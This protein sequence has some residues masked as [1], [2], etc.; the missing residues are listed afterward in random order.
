MQVSKLRFFITCICY[1]DYNIWFENYQMEHFSDILK[2]I[3]GVIR[4]RK[5]KEL[6]PYLIEYILNSLD[7]LKSILEEK[8]KENVASESKLNTKMEE[9]IKRGGLL[10]AEAKKAAKE[11]LELEDEWFKLDDEYKK[12]QKEAEKLKEEEDKLNKEKEDSSNKS[13]LLN[14]S[15][16]IA[17]YLIPI[18]LV[19]VATVA[20]INWAVESSKLGN[21]KNKKDQQAKQM[22]EMQGL[23]DEQKKKVETIQLE[24]MRIMSERDKLDKS[25]KFCGSVLT[26][27]RNILKDLDDIKLN[28]QFLNEDIEMLKESVEEDYFDCEKAIKFRDKIECIQI[29]YSYQEEELEYLK[30]IEAQKFNQEDYYFN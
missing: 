30:S 27:I 26:T 1:F 29:S 18:L 25:L 8:L 19:P 10:S 24:S 16:R 4:W 13:T 3:D 2:N 21:L 6:V 22:S 14:T 15:L 9:I 12:L 7:S 11:Q 5:E 20:V 28:S 17:A 23:I